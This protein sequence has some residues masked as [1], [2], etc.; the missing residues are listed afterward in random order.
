MEPPLRPET[1]RV[2]DTAIPPTADTPVPQ[3]PLPRRLAVALH[4]RDSLSLGPSRKIFGYEA[5]HWG[6]LIAPPVGTAQDSTAQ[7][8]TSQDDPSQDDKDSKKDCLAVDATDASGINPTT[9]RMDN[10][11]MS[12]WMNHKMVDPDASSKMLGFVVIGEIPGEVSNDELVTFFHTIP[13]PVKNTHP[14]Q[15]CVTWVASAIREMQSLGW[16]WKF[17][18]DQFKDAGLAYADERMKGEMSIE[19]KVKYYKV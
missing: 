19:P 5:Y 6:I 13:L 9:F 10:P 1:A 16:A 8:S 18:I 4:H 15:S 17:D 3:S 14:Q 12:W 7:E 2:D 11:T